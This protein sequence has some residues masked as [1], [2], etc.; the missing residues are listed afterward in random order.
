MQIVFCGTAYLTNTRASLLKLS[1]YGYFHKWCSGANQIAY[2]EL[3]YHVITAGHRTVIISSDQS[4]IVYCVVRSWASRLPAQGSADPEDECIAAKHYHVITTWHRGI[5][6]WYIIRA[7]HY[8][9]I[10]YWCARGS[11]D[12]QHPD[13]GTYWK[14]AS[15]PKCFHDNWPVWVTSHKVLPP[16]QSVFHEV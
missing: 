14:R 15:I 2:W 9:I 1:F 13:Q 5:L 16:S 6:S 8:L 10:V 3:D 7:W 12:R 4:I 11:L